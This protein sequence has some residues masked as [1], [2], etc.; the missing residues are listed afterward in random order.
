MFGPFPRRQAPIVLAG[1]FLLA[2][3]AHAQSPAPFTS[4][5]SARGVVYNMTFGPPIG[6]P[7]DGYG[8]GIADIDGDDDLDLVFLGRPDGLVGVYENNGLGVFVNRSAAS[9]VAISPS[10]AGVALFDY[11]RDGDLDLLVAQRYHPTRLYRNVGGLAFADVSAGAGLGFTAP[12]TGVSVADFD[13]D[14]WPDLHLCVYSTEVPDKLL[15]NLGDG[16]FE[17]VAAA[18]GVASLGLGYQS[19][20]SDHDRDSW[21]DLCVSNDRGVG[22]VPNQLW[23]NDGGS[24]IDVS[25]P[26]GA[27]VSL[28]SM[29]IACGDLNGD[30]RP[31]YYFT[32]LPDP[33]PPLFGVNPLLLSAA[34]GPFTRGEAE[35][36]V[37]NLRMSWGA[38]F[39][40]FDN[41]SDLDLYVNNEF[42]PNALFR[43]PGT[44]PMADIGVSM[45][46]AGSANLSFASA[47]GDLDGDGDLDLVINN[48]GGPVRLLMNQEGSRRNWIRLR[49]AGEGRVRDAVG[50]SA[51]LVAVGPKGEERA[52]Q[53]R[54]VLFGGNTYLAQN[55]PTLHFGLGDATA[56]A[57]IEV[58]WPAGGAVRTISSLAINAR[59]TVHHPSRLGDVDGDGAVGSLDWAQFAQW[60][61][62]P[63]QPGREMLDFDGNGALGAEDVDAFWQRASFARG[64]LDESGSVDA[65]DLAQMLGSWG[66]K[67]SHA[68]LD[69]DGSVGAGDLAILLG[70]WGG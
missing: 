50:A 69:L 68:D 23:R 4:E 53:W 33:E 40:D 41:D 54:E 21:P 17:D 49:V 58:R 2:G 38:V 70:A 11:D 63:L 16:T 51:T 10:G 36:G 61:L 66:S 8:M 35:W 52:P 29:G 1:A 24:F 64:D 5:H 26:T 46:V 32:N 62:G 22:N 3:A 37:S 19:V 9:G 45:G 39:W 7:Q 56:V 13:G 47:T 57:S 12:V 30:A 55:D 15:R 14:G 48:Y 31:D 28:C 42:Q 43:N 44:P 34:K 20:W 65:G 18:A 27:D 59:W 25:A 60:G 6:A 67:G